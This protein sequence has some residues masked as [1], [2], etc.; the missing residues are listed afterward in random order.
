[1]LIIVFAIIGLLGIV[2]GILSLKW[3]SRFSISSPLPI[4][5]K[6]LRIAVLVFGFLLGVASW[7]MTYAMGYRYEEPHHGTGRIVGLPFF[8][9]YFDSEGFD[10]VGPI[11]QLS[12]LANAVF[13]F[14]FPQLILVVFAKR[15]QLKNGTVRS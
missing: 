10:Y 15:W 1:M 2:I 11:T 14:L 12:A 8:V 4:G 7:P 9:A 3:L 13:W 5:W 6:N